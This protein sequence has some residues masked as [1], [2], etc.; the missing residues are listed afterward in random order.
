[1]QKQALVFEGCP[2]TKRPVR[3][4]TIRDFQLPTFHSEWIIEGLLGAN[5]WCSVW[6]NALCT[7]DPAFFKHVA[8]QGSGYLHFLCLIRLA[9]VDVEGDPIELPPAAEAH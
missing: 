6:L 7:A 5:H 2:Q 1:M 3:S 9:E 4:E 8:E